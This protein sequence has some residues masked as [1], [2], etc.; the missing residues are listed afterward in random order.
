MVKALLSLTRPANLV[1]AI[2]DVLAGMAIAG[3]FL[4]PNPP[5]APVGWL[6]LATV[7]LYGGGVVFNDVFDAELDAIERPER[8]IPSGLVSKNTATLLGTVLLL[9]G[10]I[11]SFMVNQTA[12]FLALGIAVASLVYDRFGKHHNWLGPVNMGLCRGL[13]LLLGISVIPEQVMPWAWVGLVPIAYIAAITM[14]SRGEVHGGSPTTLRAA[15]LLYALVIGCVAALAQQR[16]QLGT[17]LPFLI[18][19]G[20]YIFPPLW[21]A[22]REPVGRNIGMA[23]RAGVLSL[24]VMNA[25]WVAAFASFPLAMLV[26]CLLPLSRLLA[27]IFAVT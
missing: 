16:Q 2:A 8:A 12:G 19:F 27:K 5:P 21:R 4:I 23:V 24:I 26:F 25:A 6:T 17:A 10:I 9:V 3:Y 14:I 22:V 7:C 1:T 20:Y 15:G 11:A 13:N 18:L